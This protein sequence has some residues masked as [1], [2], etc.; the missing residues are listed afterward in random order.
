M[1]GQPQAG[2]GKS[3]TEST[4]KNGRERESVIGSATVIVT[5][6]EKE[7]KKKTV[8]TVN[9]RRTGTEKTMTV[10]AR[11]TIGMMTTKIVGQRSTGGNGREM[12][13]TRMGIGHLGTETMTGDG[14]GVVKAREL[15][16]TGET[17]VIRRR[18]KGKE[19]RPC[20]GTRPKRNEL[21]R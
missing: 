14:K 20:T 15:T 11:G 7:R 8:N 19:V 4:K 6:K 16:I 12:T 10:G 21:K 2:R 5:G 17:G 3:P 13:E 1:E 18:E 9:G